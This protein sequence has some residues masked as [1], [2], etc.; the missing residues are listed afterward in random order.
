[1]YL[2]IFNAESLFFGSFHM[3]KLK[4]MGYSLRMKKPIKK[5]KEWKSIYLFKVGYVLELKKK[6]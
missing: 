5:K 2:E 6:H 3:L 4:V 1:M